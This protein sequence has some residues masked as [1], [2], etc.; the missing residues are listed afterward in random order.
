M[1]KIRDVLDNKKLLFLIILCIVMF[2]LRLANI[3]E[4]IY[5]DESNFAFS[6]ANADEF[7]FNQ[8]YYSPL[9]MN[10]IELFFIAIFGFVI[11]ILLKIF[12]S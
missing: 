12:G 8:K 11:W 4:A 10:W 9:F 5:D 7:G 2:T 6:V 1:K 3:N